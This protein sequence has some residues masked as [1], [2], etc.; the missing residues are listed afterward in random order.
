MIKGLFIFE[1]RASFGYSNNLLKKLKNSK[2]FK[3]YT[4]IT[5]THLSKELGNS[6]KDLKLNKIKIDFKFK[7]NSK[8]ISV[9]TSNLIKKVDFI[10]NKIKPKFIFI[11]GDRI[12]LMPIA[13]TAMYNDVVICHVQAGDKSGHIDDVT[14]M[15][16]A[17]ISHLHFPATEVAKKRLIKLGEEKFRIFKVGAPQLDDIKKIAFNKNFKF[18]GLNLKKEKYFVILQHSVFKDK[19]NYKKIFL[20]TLEACLKFDY[21]IFII[22]PNYDPGYKSIIILIN[23]FQKKFPNKIKIFKHI[24]RNN[25]LSLIYFSSCF[26]G[27]SSC[28]ILETPSLN[29]GT[30][31][32][33]DRQEGRE[34]NENIFNSTYESLDIVR[35]IKRGILYNKKNKYKLIKNIHG[36][37]SSAKRIFKV[38]NKIG[39]FKS[40]LNKKTTY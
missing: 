24:D 26:V 16:L 25:F 18:K 7:F 12:E 27:N 30:V 33:G 9:G 19:K 35:A 3:I 23:K 37:G 36:D 28:G 4:L 8:N 10:I 34:Q 17:K 1:S 21:K 6:L 15:A 5:G 14:R 32:I 38:L 31:N 22:Y 40:L 11:F 20:N 2:K 39:S 13:L 29:I